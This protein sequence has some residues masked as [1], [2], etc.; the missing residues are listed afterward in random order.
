MVV[1]NCNPSAGEIKTR[2]LT[3]AH[4]LVSLAKWVSSTAVRE[5]ILN[6]N[7]DSSLPEVISIYSQSLGW[8][9]FLLPSCSTNYNIT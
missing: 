6:G 9:S 5:P 3:G 7:T 8:L 1:C 4:W 2:G